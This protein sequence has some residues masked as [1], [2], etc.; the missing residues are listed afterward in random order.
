MSSLARAWRELTEAAS[1]ERMSNADRR[2]LVACSGGADSAALAIGLAAV[3]REVVIGHVVHDLR[4]EAESLSDR[5]AVRRLAGLLGLEFVESLLRVRAGVGNVEA[6]ARKARYA[7]LAGLAAKTGCRYVATA[8]HADD[9]LESVLMALVRGAGPRGLSGVARRRS[10]ERS[11]SIGADARVWI[12]RPLLG[13]EDG[14]GPAW[15][16]ADCEALCRNAGWV[17]SE[18]STNADVGL[19]RNA[20]RRDVAP[21]LKRLRPQAARRAAAAARVQRQLAELLADA[22]RQ[23]SRDEARSGEGAWSR[24]RLRSLAAVVAGE[25]LR[26]EMM[27]CGV[28][29]DAIG[30]RVLGPIVRAIRDRST[31]PRRFFCGDASVFVTARAVEIRPMPP[32]GT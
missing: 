17:W 8:H 24:E 19:L 16:R 30:Q 7:A 15:E 1:G 28:G 29:G 32:A 20:I 4:P 21:V 13:T 22:A 2:T 14:R 12:I 9:Q 26:R 5:D 23:A 6:R 25:I 3:S 27:G 10:A 11:A 31:E 18:D